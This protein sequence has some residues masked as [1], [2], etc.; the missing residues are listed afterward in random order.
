MGGS[1]HDEHDR[2][3]GRGAEALRAGPG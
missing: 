2:R 3:Y 1:L